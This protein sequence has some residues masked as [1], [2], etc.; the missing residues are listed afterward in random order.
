MSAGAPQVQDP[1][2]ARV[3]IPLER[4]P[5]TLKTAASG[6][7]FLPPLP[8]HLSPQPSGEDQNFSL[9]LFGVVIYCN[10]TKYSKT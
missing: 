9:I 5:C 4:P 10:L 1:S 6:K 7:S 3:N 2:A 8:Q